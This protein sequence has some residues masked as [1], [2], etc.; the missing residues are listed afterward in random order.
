MSG[1]RA[2]SSRSR[3]AMWDKAAPNRYPAP[4]GVAIGLD[5]THRACFACC[6]MLQASTE[7]GLCLPVSKQTP[8]WVCAHVLM[9][10]GASPRSRCATPIS[11]PPPVPCCPQALGLW[12]KLPW[13][14]WTQLQCQLR[15]FPL[16]R[17][18]ARGDKRGWQPAA[19]QQPSASSDSLCRGTLSV[20]LPR[21]TGPH[22]VYIGVVLCHG[23]RMG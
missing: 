9:L 6:M 19:L 12:Q 22:F 8:P 3:V 15:A 10:S 17:F 1:C 18:S 2:E 7:T 14:Q 20:R 4:S 23:F 16:H 11:S 5:L 21:S 13:R